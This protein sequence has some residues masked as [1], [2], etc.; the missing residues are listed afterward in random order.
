MDGWDIALLIVAGYVAVSA[1]V[2]LTLQRRDLML[3][4]LR[5][6]VTQRPQDTEEE[7]APRRKSA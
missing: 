6:Q 2:R 4:A 3:T 5:Q 7:E 1:L